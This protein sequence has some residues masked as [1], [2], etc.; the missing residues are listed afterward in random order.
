MSDFYPWA[1]RL[2][3]ACAA[4]LSLALAGTAAA[5]ETARGIVFEDL[6]GNGVLD[7][8]EPGIAGVAVANG[9]DVVLTDEDG[10]YELPVGDD[11]ILFVTKPSGYQVHIDE[12]NVPR[13]YYIHKPHGSPDYYYKGVAPTGPLPESVDFPLTRIEEPEQFRIVA[14]ADT[15]PETSQEV[16]WLKQGAFSEM[17]GLDAAFA[18]VLGDIMFD[19]LEFFRGYINAF[20]PVG[21]PFYH[22]IGNHDLNFDAPDNTTAGETYQRYFGPMWYSWEVGGVRFV[23]LNNI[24][25]QGRTEE[26]PYATNR[27]VAQIEEH[28]LEWLRNDLAHADPEQTIVFCMHAP[29]YSAR[30]RNPHIRNLEGLF[31]VLRD[32]PRVL[33]L[34]GHTHTTNIRTFT[35]EDGWEG[36]GEFI[37]LNAAVVSGSWWS[38]PKDHRGIPF[39][40]QRDGVPAGYTIVDFD[41]GEYTWHFKAVGLPAEYQMEVYPPG[42]HASG[43]TPA[44]TLLVNVFYGTEETTVEYRLNGGEWLPM[45]Y[46]PQEDPLAQQLYSGPGDTGKPW[47]NPVTAFHIWEAELEAAPPRTPNRWDVRATLPDGRILTGVRIE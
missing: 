29:L 19:H 21:Y 18:V 11:T 5:Q 13:F 43:E 44:R 25:W 32:R 14:L 1:K 3:P 9:L 8:G 40:L 37:D 30:S 46:R 4:L 26:N 31:E 24:H 23:T 45:E 38:G 22:V 36:D 41:G 39:S 16:A 6:N 34:S 42:V 12:K 33:A 20:A 17:A 10:R 35:E 2:R 27:Y 47:V 15:Q 7:D 28:Q